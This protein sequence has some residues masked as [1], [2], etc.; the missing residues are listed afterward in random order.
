MASTRSSYILANNFAPLSKALYCMKN[1]A[2]AFTLVTFSTS[3]FACFG[4]PDQDLIILGIRL[5]ALNTF[6]V[7]L[8][9]TLRC[10]ANFRDVFKSVTIICASLALPIFMYFNTHGSGDCGEGDVVA[11][12]VASIILCLVVAYE[13]IN[14]F[15]VR[16][17]L[18]YNKLFKRDK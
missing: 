18:Q 17:K 11:F 3:T 8:S 12:K 16:R 14:L 6:L 15:K 13:L 2:I 5:L 7:F 10:I 1:L 9:L 4:G